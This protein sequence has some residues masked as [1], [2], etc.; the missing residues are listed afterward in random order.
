MQFY[1][2]AMGELKTDAK[3]GVIPWTA[4]RTYA[5]TYGLDLE[6]F[7]D[8]VRYIRAME[9]GLRGEQAKEDKT[10]PEQEQ[11]PAPE[12]P[13]TGKRSLVDA[14]KDRNA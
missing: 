4:I 8:L 11:E 13:A 9:E 6:Q 7:E 5:E 1:F 3:N 10:A 14:Q 2:G 12:A